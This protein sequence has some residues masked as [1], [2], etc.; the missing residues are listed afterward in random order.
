MAL[1]CSM[2]HF[3]LVAY[4]SKISVGDADGSWLATEWAKD[5]GSRLGRRAMTHPREKSSNGQLLIT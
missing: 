3:R 2:C 5:L 1:C 4:Y